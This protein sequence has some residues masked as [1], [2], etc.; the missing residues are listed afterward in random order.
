MSNTL[1]M[2]YHNL[3]VMLDAG[4]PILRSLNTV[5]SDLEPRMRNAFLKLSDGVSN[6]NPLAETMSQNPRLFNPVDVM[7]VRVAETSGSLSES[8]GLLAK[9]HELSGRLRR[10]MLS[11]MA[12]PMLLITLVAFV[13]PLPGFILGGWNIKSVLLAAARIL[14]LFWVPA[15][16]I[17][18]IV[19]MTPATGP[20]RR[21][22]DRAVL[23]IPILGKA[24]YKLAVSRYCW[25]FH[26]LC[27]AGVPVTDSVDMAVSA[28]GNAVVADLFRPA[29][30]SVKAGG[31]VCEGFSSKL[32]ADFKDIWR[33]GEESGTLDDATKR[34]ADN[35]TEAAEFW[36]DEFARWFPRLVYF[37]VCLVMAYYIFKNFASIAS[38][39]TTF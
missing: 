14:L 3:S 25:V 15:G 28:T 20:A 34:L 2:A 21:L 18:L 36:F 12:L 4:V 13:A 37:L 24:M 5:G 16:L 8:I 6:G 19:R 26:M 9:W 11:G 35:Y 23:R 31:L 32:P 22:L 33:V 30:E 27:K 39:M 38:T 1:A 7:L 10:K 29:V 17:F